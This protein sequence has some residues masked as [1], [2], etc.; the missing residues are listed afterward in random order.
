MSPFKKE[1]NE[2][3]NRYSF[4][5]FIIYCNLN[6]LKF[7]NKNQDQLEDGSSLEFSSLPISS[8]NGFINLLMLI[9]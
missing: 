3:I 7:V 8:F 6:Y 4:A 2:G 5:S 1:A 9:I